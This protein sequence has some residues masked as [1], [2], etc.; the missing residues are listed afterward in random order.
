MKQDAL[1]RWIELAEH[2]RVWLLTKEDPARVMVDPVPTSI[3]PPN[4]LLASL[5]EQLCLRKKGRR[6]SR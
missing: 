2:A 5:R 3:K 1:L 6:L 4:T